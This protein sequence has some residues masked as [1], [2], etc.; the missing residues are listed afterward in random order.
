MS[1]SNSRKAR[2]ARFLAA[3]DRESRFSSSQR[4][5]SQADLSGRLSQN[6]VY[7]VR[8]LTDVP[9]NSRKARF[10]RFWRSS[11]ARLASRAVQGCVL[12]LI[13]LVACGQNEVYPDNGV[14]NLANL[15]HVRTVSRCP[16]K[17][18]LPL[19]ER[20]TRFTRVPATGIK[21][22]LQNEV[23][24]VPALRVHAWL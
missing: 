3:S 15:K 23:Y 20:K 22:A 13:C 18:S 14:P 19:S 12:K 10:A 9:S 17:I 1:P 4:L 5:R 2:F 6:E 16:K 7:P 11:I 8:R 24:R 21:S